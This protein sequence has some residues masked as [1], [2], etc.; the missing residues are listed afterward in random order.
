MLP[1]LTQP[2]PPAHATIK[3]GMNMHEQQKQ[4]QEYSMKACMPKPLPT[5]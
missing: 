5:T 2:D 3:A 4:Q 1:G